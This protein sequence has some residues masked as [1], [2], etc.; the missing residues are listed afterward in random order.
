MALVA[1]VAWAA[2]RSY[3]DRLVGDRNA[4][5]QITASKMS[6]DR[7]EGLYVA[8]GDVVITR[9]GQVLKAN[10]ARYNEKT[11]MVEA[12]GD[13]VLE[14]NGDIVRA[15]KAVF[16][17]NS[18]TGKITKGRIFLRENHYYISGDDMEKTG[19][20]TYVVKGCHVTTCEGDKPDWSITGSEVEITVEG[21][22]TVK[23]AVFRIRDLPAF[24]LPYALFPATTKRQSGVLPPAVGYSS[25]NGVQV[26]VPIYWA[27]SDR[28]D[29][30]FYEQ[31][32]S[33]RGLMQGFEYRYVAEDESKG[34]FLFDILQDKIGQKD[35][36]DPD[37]LNISPLPRTNETRYWLRSR[38]NQ[39]L[40]LG[41]KAKL[42]TDYVSDR[43]YFKEFYGNLF[44]Y[45]A[46]PNIVRD[47]GR[48]LDDIWSPTRRSAL[49]L[50]RDQPGY[51]LQAVSSYYERPDNP[52]DDPTPQPLGGLDFNL[53][54]G[55]L[56]I[57]P[58]F[59]ALNTD[60]DYI[61]REA[62]PRGQRASLTPLLTYPMWLG[63]Y[64]QF[65]PSV[66]YTRNAQWLDQ[67]VRGK[68]KQY[69]DAYDAQ[70]KFSTVVE[71][72]YE[73]DW[74]SAN[75]LKHK[76]VPSLLY[77]YRV[78]KDLDA[79]RP[80]FESMDADGK[81]NRVALALDNFLDAR[82]ETEK[83]GAL[84]EQ[85]TRFTMI[86]GYRIDGTWWDEGLSKEERPF[87]PLIGILTLRPLSNLYLDTEVHWDYYEKN[88][89]F[90]DVS[91]ALNI[92]RSGGRADSI[93]VD[94]QYVKDGNKGF[95]ANGFVNLGYGFGVGGGVRRD[96][97]A[98]SSLAKGLYLDYQ[99]QCW[100]VRVI[101]DNLDGV[102]SIMVHFRLLGLGAIGMK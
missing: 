80:W 78:H 98:K 17:L 71:R 40:P 20:D 54:P 96:L 42:D 57:A 16:D 29:A 91:L 43:D 75:K 82:R 69:R 79:Y 102:G 73:T 56:P 15:A 93:G 12:I 5:W 11:G 39:Q 34:D 92:A 2:D 76:I 10:E 6:Y 28:M 37:Q 26:E 24:F 3:G 77:N 74:A 94:Y 35:L 84:Y 100:G 53:L 31:Y 49:R 7:D 70:A 36:T 13:V 66:G 48:P 47:F 41:V 52:P 18:Q 14:T 27:I 86:Q 25:L 21:Y 19:P 55:T 50:D 99:S 32:L 38:T 45:R 63:R 51:S 61:W 23:N 33:E 8:E 83:E 1:D 89:P 30:T 65:E 58:F 46:R 4:K 90:A 88:I 101:S 87:E 64:L 60:Y 95:N 62:G 81:M 85:W 67:S 97:N 22:G 72:I 44:G 59:M 9:G 68:D